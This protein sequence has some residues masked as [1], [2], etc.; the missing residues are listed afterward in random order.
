MLV[1][2]IYISFILHSKIKGKSRMFCPWSPYDSQGNVKAFLTHRL[3]HQR[4][5]SLMCVICK[6][7]LISN[8]ITSFLIVTLKVFVGA[9][10][11]FVVKT[12][13][14]NGDG[15]HLAWILSPSFFLLMADITVW[16]WCFVIESTFAFRIFFNILF[17]AAILP[18]NH[19]PT[20]Q[21]YFSILAYCLLN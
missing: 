12:I 21:S 7:P 2:I 10:V 16:S 4:T 19:R 13:I 3:T 8:I 1:G 20:K 5:E 17:K 14:K 11:C 18:V 9:G 6:M 15:S